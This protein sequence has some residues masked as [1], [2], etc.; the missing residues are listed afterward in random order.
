MI[1]YSLVAEK[2][3]GFTQTTVLRLHDPSGGSRCQRKS[4]LIE[5]SFYHGVFWMIR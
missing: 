5:H 1:A 2:S 4:A 3:N